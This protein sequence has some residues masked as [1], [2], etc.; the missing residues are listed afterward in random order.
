MKYCSPECEWMNSDFQAMRYQ[1]WNYSCVEKRLDC[2]D[3]AIWTNRGIPIARENCGGKTLS[4]DSKMEECSVSALRC[5]ILDRQLK[6][7]QNLKQDNKEYSRLVTEKNKRLDEYKKESDLV[8]NNNG[9]VI[10]CS[11]NCRERWYLNDKISNLEQDKTA[12]D[13][14]IHNL[15]GEKELL[16]NH[17]D[18]QRAELARLNRQRNEQEKELY[19]A[20]VENIELQKKIREL[21]EEAK[22]C[23]MKG[24]E[25]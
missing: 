12:L 6:E 20:R 22:K 3:I 21:K 13:A 9:E 23:P 11:H 14:R 25:N 18:N 19:Q 17:C 16:Q 24:G 15:R 1:S 10:G 2:G 5:R 8:I 7:I 4:E